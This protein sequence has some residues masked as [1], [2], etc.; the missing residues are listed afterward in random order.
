MA[1]ERRTN[2]AEILQALMLY[3]KAGKRYSMLKDL[4]DMFFCIV[5]KWL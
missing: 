3:M 4:R 2:H 5:E 1:S